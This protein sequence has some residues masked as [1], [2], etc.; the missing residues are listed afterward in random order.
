MYDIVTVGHFCID[1]ILLPH[2]PTPFVVLGGPVTYVSLAARRL[3]ARVAIISKTGSD[4]PEAYRWWLEQEG[5]NL[6][7]LSKTEDASTTRFELNYNEDLSERRLILKKK[8]PKLTIEDL[9]SPLKALA[10]HI[11][12]IADEITYDVVEKL[13]NYADVLS[14][15]PQGLVRKFNEDGSVFCS[16]PDDLRML[17]LVNI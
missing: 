6:S 1:S 9:R 15:D 7:W 5:I 14:L 13:K 12:P 2:R 11:A 3:E 8:A 4:F 16:K 10:I 17:D